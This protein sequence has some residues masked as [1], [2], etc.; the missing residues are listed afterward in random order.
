MRSLYVLLAVCFAL[1]AVGGG[2]AVATE[3]T[4]LIE[5]FTSA[6]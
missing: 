2:T 5:M 6:G 3:R 1:A 4:V